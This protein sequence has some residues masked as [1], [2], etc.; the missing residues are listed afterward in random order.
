MRRSTLI[1]EKILKTDPLSEVILTISGILLFAP[2]LVLLV[3]SMSHA[4]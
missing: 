3:L 1:E 4:G 2:L